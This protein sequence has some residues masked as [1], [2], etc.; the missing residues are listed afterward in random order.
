[1]QEKCGGAR[2]RQRCGNLAA[3]DAGLAHARDDDAPAAFEQELDRLLEL[4][5][6]TVDQRE[7]GVRL[8]LQD[9]AGD[10]EIYGHN[11]HHARAP[12]AP[13]GVFGAGPGIA[14]S[15]ATA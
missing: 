2:A 8:R 5:V 9:L 14:C 1:M 12:C 13:T 4:L 15:C 11:S 10:R 3:D 6:E 7:D